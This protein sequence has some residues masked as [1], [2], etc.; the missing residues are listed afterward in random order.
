MERY[1]IAIVGSG[2][3][4]LSA[5]GHADAMDRDAGRTEPSYVLLESRPQPSE[6]I[7]R[8]Q[9]GKH[10]MA[11]PAVVPLRSDLQFAAGTRE[12]VLSSW[13]NDLEK[14]G[15]NVRYGCEVTAISGEHPDFVITLAGGEEISGKSIVLAIGMQGN[16][17]KLGVAGEELPFVNYTLD[18]PDEYNDETI[19]VVG[20]GDAAIE[21]AVALARS[22]SVI[23]VNRRDE[24]ARAKEGN[25]SLITRAIDDG[26][27]TCF[28]CVYTR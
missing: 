10:V 23:I 13:Q 26:S 25:L 4:G 17:R 19:V 5:A 1:K 6:T 27:I 11:E 14:L 15:V 12:A 24:F 16:P 3:A 22:N 28:Y 8:F 18:D 21:N 2:P 9:K 20:A 7:F